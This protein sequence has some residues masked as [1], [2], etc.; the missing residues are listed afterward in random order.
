MSVTLNP[1]P[2]S[3]SGLR[4][5]LQASPCQG[6]CYA[7]APGDQ[8]QSLLQMAYGPA[9]AGIQAGFMAHNAHLA[10]S[11]AADLS[12]MIGQIMMF[13]MLQ[14]LQ[15]GLQM[16]PAMGPSA[17]A[18][19][20]GGG[21]AAPTGNP[22]LAQ[23]VQLSMLTGCPPG[24]LPLLL[25]QSVIRQGAG[26]AIREGRTSVGGQ[27]TEATGGRIDRAL[28]ESWTPRMSP[29]SADVKP[30]S[31]LDYNDQL[32]NGGQT[33]RSAGCYMTALTMAASKITGDQSLNPSVANQRIRAAGGYS[34]SNLIVDRAANALGMNVVDRQAYTAGNQRELI[35][36]LDNSLEQ[37]RPVVAGVDYKS[38]SSSS[39]SD[40]DHFLTITGRN[41]D[42]TYSAIDPAGGHE[43]TFEQAPDGTL[44]SGKY[45][46]SE[47]LFL[48]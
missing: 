26:D 28:T 32:G 16:A 10:L 6:G 29:A 39:T 1:A 3:Q 11:P 13:P 21:G 8:L 42:G 38:G 43:I 20:F 25:P 48:E 12:S 30:M 15:S 45:T 17:A 14:A 35:S 36:A 18:Q 24:L 44:R 47:M 4:S 40:A 5:S 46:L 7:I 31:Q 34:G 33:I 2:L 41:A 37:G 19:F 27:G 9:A 23:L 22:A